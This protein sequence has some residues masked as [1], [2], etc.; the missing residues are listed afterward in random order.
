MSAAMSFPIDFDLKRLDAVA[1]AKLE[2]KWADECDQLGMDYAHFATSDIDH[3]RAIC[4]EPVEDPRYGIF[5][6]VIDGSY[7]AILHL[8]RALLPG[9]KGYTLRVL[10]FLGSPRYDWVIHEPA[11]LGDIISGLLIKILSVAHSVMRSR[12]IK[13]HVSGMP[14]RAIFSGLAQKLHSSGQVTEVATRG[15]WLHMA[16]A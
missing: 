12:Y 7:E 16:V 11:E 4:S 13:I 6:L 8:N 9:T 15:S 1:F 3:A 10:W 2:E 14:D 5:A